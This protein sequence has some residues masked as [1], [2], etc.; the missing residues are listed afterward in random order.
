[1]HPQHHVKF[2][3]KTNEQIPRKLQMEEQTQGQ[4]EGRIEGQMEGWTYRNYFV[5]PFLLR[6]GGPKKH[7]ETLHLTCLIMCVIH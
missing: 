1:M 4:T 5:G 3:K 7:T 2:W 6:P